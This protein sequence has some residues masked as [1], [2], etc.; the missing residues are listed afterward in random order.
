MFITLPKTKLTLYGYDVDINVYVA[1]Y[2]FQIVSTP[3]LDI[4]RS[5]V[6]ERL[7]IRN[8]NVY[9]LILIKIKVKIYF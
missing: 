1:F 6:T 8:K 3:G 2:G 5:D 4:Y 9:G 7:L